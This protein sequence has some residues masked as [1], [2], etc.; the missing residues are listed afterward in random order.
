MLQRTNRWQILTKCDIGV[1]SLT[2]NSTNLRG[3]SE[4]THG[5]EFFDNVHICITLPPF[6][7][8]KVEDAKVMTARYLT[9][10]SFQFHSDK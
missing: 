1:M 3:G 4:I 9:T 6:P 8:R 10:F 7:S 5:K 2:I